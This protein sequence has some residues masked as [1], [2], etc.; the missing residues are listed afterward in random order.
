MNG[1]FANWQT[2]AEGSSFCNFGWGGTQKAISAPGSK[3]RG[4]LAFGLLPG[5]RT[6]GE[7]LQTPYFNWGWNYA[8]SASSP[9][10]EIAYLFSLYATSP[11]VSTEAVRA[12]GGFFDPF[13]TAHYGD[14]RIR[15]TYTPEFLEVH[16]RGMRDSMPDLYLRG[17]AHYFTSLQKFVHRADEKR[18]EPDVA[19]RTVAAEW[20]RISRRMGFESQ[21]EQW[22]YLRGQYPSRCAV[23]CV[24]DA[25]RKLVA[26]APHAGRPRAA[27]GSDECPSPWRARSG[28]SCRP[29]SAG[30][31]GRVG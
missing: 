22:N 29:G 8:V 18:M 21:R 10:P 2:F 4:A 7:L 25:S 23:C 6:N 19:L 26:R 31:P 28:R 30:L 5:G 17:H 11:R 16:E 14:E 9:E 20:R 27:G 12:S 24:R 1:L 15:E 3:V 13:R